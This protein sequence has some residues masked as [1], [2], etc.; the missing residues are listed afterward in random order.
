MALQWR[1][2]ERARTP[3]DLDILLI[4]SREDLHATL[5]RAAQ[6]E[7]GDWFRYLVG[8]PAHAHHAGA[9]GLRFS[10]KALLDG[11]PFETFHLD[12]AWGDPVVEA[13]EELPAP[14]LL[15]FADIEPLAMPCYPITQHIA[16]KQYAYTRPRASGESSWVKDLV[17]SS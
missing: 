13:P 12:V 1:L 8:Q 6:L 14:S 7:L 11:R 15:G 2:G 4:G 16:E 9:G 5:V 10:V 3:Q 17:E